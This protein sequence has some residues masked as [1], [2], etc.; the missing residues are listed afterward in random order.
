MA[1]CLQICDIALDVIAV[2]DSVY[3]S[4]DE[5]T[6][7]TITNLFNVSEEL[8]MAAAMGIVQSYTGN[9][10]QLAVDGGSIVKTKLWAKSLMIR[11][12]FVKRRA[13]TKTPKFNCTDFDKSKAQFLF[14]AKSFIEI[15][16]IPDSLILNWYQTT[17][18]YVPVSS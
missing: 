1:Y 7:S 3:S 9:G 15:E 5:D 4:V 2:Y 8:V 13:T 11:M 18:C 6:R 17:L 10:Y 12:S 16:D 14:D